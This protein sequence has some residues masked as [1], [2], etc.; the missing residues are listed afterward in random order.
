MSTTNIASFVADFV[1]QYDY[2]ALADPLVHELKSPEE[3]LGDL[4][5]DER[6]R[7][8]FSAVSLGGASRLRKR[9]SWGNALGHSLGLKRGLLG[10]YLHGRWKPDLTVQDRSMGRV[11]Q[12]LIAGGAKVIGGGL[13]ES[14]TGDDGEKKPRKLPFVHVLLGESSYCV[15]PQLLSIL[16]VYACF[17]KRDSVLLSAL[18][19]RA[20]EWLKSQSVSELDSILVLPAT[21]AL[22]FLVSGPEAAGR[23]ILGSAEASV[24]RGR[25]SW[26][27]LV[28]PWQRDTYSA[29]WE[30]K[31]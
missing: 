7:L 29:W 26:A 16:G 30:M 12:A 2:E 11:M 24:A 5:G 18:R 31:T 8:R 4:P 14:R 28:N 3:I 20:S 27:V 21:V 10:A 23:E 1:S 6:E 17:K 15:C 9:S 19:L 25:S 22:A 13:L